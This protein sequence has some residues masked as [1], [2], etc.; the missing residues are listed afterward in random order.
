MGWFKGDHSSDLYS[1][2]PHDA[3]A[4]LVALA[5]VEAVLARAQET[6]DRGDPEMALLLCEAV[7]TGDAQNP[8]AQSLYAN[9]HQALLAEM[10]AG[11]DNFW[12]GGWLRHRLGK[13]STA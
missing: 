6:L 9:V 3:F 10:E 1:T 12:L 5:G 13:P 7:L 4:E 8:R 11:E 2:R